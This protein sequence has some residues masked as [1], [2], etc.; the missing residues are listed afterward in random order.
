MLGLLRSQAEA[1][2]YMSS[3]LVKRGYEGYDFLVGHLLDRY[4][5]DVLG[6]QS[7]RVVDESAIDDLLTLVVE[8]IVEMNGFFNSRQQDV[9]D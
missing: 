3:W 5:S 6:A 2:D 1:F 8:L 4:F 9:R 7:L